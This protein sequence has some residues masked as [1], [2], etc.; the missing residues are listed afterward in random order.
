MN[1]PERNHKLTKGAGV[2][3]SFTKKMS[4][5][6]TG[7]DEDLSLKHRI[8]IDKQNSIGQYSSDVSNLG[9]VGVGSAKS[10]PDAQKM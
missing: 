6:S 7:A 1:D 5:D 9:L 10:G 4:Y 2:C 8:N 3:S